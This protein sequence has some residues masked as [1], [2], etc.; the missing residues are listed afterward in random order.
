[1]DN[2]N[3]NANNN[4]ANNNDI[5]DEEAILGDLS[6][7]M[8]TLTVDLSTTRITSTS[9]RRPRSIIDSEEDDDLFEIDEISYVSSSCGL[10]VGNMDIESVGSDI[11]SQKK[12]VRTWGWA[13]KNKW[14][15]RAT[16]SKSNG[17]IVRCLYPGYKQTYATSSMTTSGINNHLGKVHRITRD[18]GVNDG[19]LSRGGPLDVLLRSFTQPR[20]FDPTSFNDLLVRSIVKSPA[21]QELLNHATMANEPQVRLPSDDTMATKTKR[22]YFEMEEQVIAM[23]ADVHKVSLTADGWTSPFQDDF[24]GVTAH[25]IDILE[26]FHLGEQL[27]S[28]TTHNASNMAKMMR[29]LLL[30]YHSKT[31]ST[32]VYAVATAMDPMMRFDWWGANDWGEKNISKSARTWSRIFGINITKEKKDQSNWMSTQNGR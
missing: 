10:P 18:S 29:D 20:A 5:F 8:W 17:V 24:L 22:K 1:M 28:I 23:F 13:V 6:Q 16:S 4:N 25:W 7:K 26:R 27:Q 3:N 14:A 30:D 32:P 9:I 11:T 21:F 2:I 31:D 15:E 12:G 19:S